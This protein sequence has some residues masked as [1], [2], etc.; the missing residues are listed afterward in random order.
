MLSSVG[1]IF[2]ATTLATDFQQGCSTMSQQ[3]PAR[4]GNYRAYADAVVAAL[5]AMYNPASGLFG[6]GEENWWTSANALE[7]VIDYS[8]CTGSETYLDLVSTT[9]QKNASANFI[10][11]YYDDEGWWALTWIKAYDLTGER[12]YLAMAQTIFADMTTGWDDHCA[13]GVWWSKDRKYKNAIPNELFLTLA[14]RLH[15]RVPGESSYLDWANRE[16]SWF[17]ASG[18][19]NDHH[20]I[21]DGLNDQC[22][23]NGEPTWTYNQGVI[24]GG[25]VEM[26]HCSG[27]PSYL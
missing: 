7:A 24:L 1:S 15:Q 22:Q 20:L 11:N 6:T 16:W 12:I 3:T 2:S 5:K 23:N 14:A 26:F 4:A 21:N 8:A 13:G 17:S 27:N 9:F 25:L 18:M 19:I 10:N